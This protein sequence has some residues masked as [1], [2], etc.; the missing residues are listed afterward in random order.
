M[1]TSRLFTCILL[2]P[3]DARVDVG[4]SALER[5]VHVSMRVCARDPH[6]QAEGRIIDVLT[7][8]LL[9]DKLPL[10]RQEVVVHTPTCSLLFL[11][12]TDASGD[13][14]KPLLWPTRTLDITDYSVKIH[15]CQPGHPFT[16]FKHRSVAFK[17]LW[18]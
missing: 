11:S 5:S 6:L 9:P 15:T 8:G 4:G 16:T 13:R 10:L 3:Q 14:D 2:F 18:L 17:S 1:V 7:T 12:C